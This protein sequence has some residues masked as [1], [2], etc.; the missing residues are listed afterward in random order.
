MEKNKVE[1]EPKKKLKI[2]VTSHNFIGHILPLL[3]I[4]EE[5]IN[6]GHEVTIISS[7]TIHGDTTY[8]KF[9]EKS[10]SEIKAKLILFDDGM[11][12]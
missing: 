6:N 1:V 8:Q 4:S 12:T 11:N 9:L 10:T 3:H 7:K 2:I 5:L